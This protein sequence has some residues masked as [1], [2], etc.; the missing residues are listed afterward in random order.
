M[1]RHINV[2]VA[3]VIAGVFVFTALVLALKEGDRTETEAGSNR[4]GAMSDKA[5]GL[6]IVVDS[7]SSRRVDAKNPILSGAEAVRRE[8]KQ[9]DDAIDREAFEGGAAEKEVVDEEFEV[10]LAGLAK[11]SPANLRK[12][13]LEHVDAEVREVAIHYLVEPIYMS[14][15]RE[16][17][18]SEQVSE[19]IDILGKTLRDYDESVRMA[20]VDAFRNIHDQVLEK[21]ATYTPLADVALHDSS[22]EVREFALEILV[23]YHGKGA[24]PV[25]QQALGDSSPDVAS[26]ASLLIEDYEAG[27]F[28]GEFKSSEKE[29]SATP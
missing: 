26:A 4:A 28:D 16:P 11:A 3:I 25:V 24:M 21:N 1:S 23:Y 22:E 2:G 13:A 20:S 14:E 5:N 12:E 15:R 19:V 9:T 17:V 27:E 29:G 10:Y 18:P 7:V 8:T 6:P